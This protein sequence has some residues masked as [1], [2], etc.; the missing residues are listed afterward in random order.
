M[1]PAVLEKYHDRHDERRRHLVEH[2]VEQHAHALERSDEEE[3]HVGHLED[4]HACGKTGV[5]R[6]QEHQREVTDDYR[7]ELGI[8]RTHVAFTGVH[9]PG[10]YDEHQQRHD[11]HGVD[12]LGR[13]A[14]NS[15]YAVFQLSEGQIGERAHSFSPPSV[16]AKNSSSR[17]RPSVSE[18]LRVAANSPFIIMWATSQ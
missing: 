13:G 17:S 7:P 11:Y 6:H 15:L 10:E 3:V 16:M 12:K 5:G 9:V 2:A 14:K 8:R 4:A 1:H 18:A